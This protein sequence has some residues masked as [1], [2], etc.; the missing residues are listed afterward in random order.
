LNPPTPPD[1]LWHVEARKYD[2]AR[3]LTFPAFLLSDNGERLW[4]RSQVGGQIEHLTR[5]EVWPI[6]RPSD[7]IFWR[8]RWYN[9]YLNYEAD[10]RLQEFY[11][12][13]GLPPVISTADHT[14]SFVDLDLDVQIWPDGRI[15]LLDE[16]EFI[17]HAAHYAYPEDVQRS[18]RQA[19]D[20]LLALWRVR[21]VPFD[22]VPG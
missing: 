16:D 3:H 12:N 8:G 6:T 15:E 7:M 18:A 5:G 17:A 2:G 20:D 4:F 19:V 14:L 13:V 22:R 21:A 11:C 9:V 10:G 1:V